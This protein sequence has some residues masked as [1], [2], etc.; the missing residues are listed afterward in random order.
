MT[1]T[2]KLQRIRAKCVEL[3][4]IAEKRT[5]GKW[6]W[7]GDPSNETELFR[8]NEAPWLIAD[9]RGVIRGDILCSK[10]DSAFIAACAGPAEAAW[11]STIAAIEEIQRNPAEHETSLLKQAILSAWPDEL[12]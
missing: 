12:L 5:P 1:T 7:D 3:L 4:E 8:K 2:E 6:A 11:K 10:D 9:E